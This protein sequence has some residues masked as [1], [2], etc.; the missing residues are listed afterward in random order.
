M[1]QQK[2]FANV[3]ICPRCG[4]HTVLDEQTTVCSG[5]SISLIAPC[6]RC[7]SDIVPLDQYCPKCG[8]DLEQETRKVVK[9]GRSNWAKFGLALVIIGT[10]IIIAMPILLFMAPMSDNIEVTLGI[11]VRGFLVGMFNIGVGLWFMR[12]H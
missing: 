5:C 2:E 1:N 12:K 7:N 6:P 10:T 9:A 3:F 11:T 4:A 8:L